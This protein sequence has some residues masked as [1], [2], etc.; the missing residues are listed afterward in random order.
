[1]TYS[2]TATN[3]ANKFEPFQF[4]TF[5]WIPLD[6]FI[7]FLNLRN[8]SPH[9]FSWATESLLWNFGGKSLKNAN[10]GRAMLTCSVR[11]LA[12][13][14]YSQDLFLCPV[15]FL[16]WPC[17]RISQCALSRVM[18]DIAF[19]SHLRISNCVQYCLGLLLTLNSWTSYFVLAVCLDSCCSSL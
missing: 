1:M 16:D 2:L 10:S 5:P 9:L 12:Y 14:Y 3:T 4:F 17:L 6:A 15:Y 19:H 13:T 8:Y 11:S 7:R 18:I